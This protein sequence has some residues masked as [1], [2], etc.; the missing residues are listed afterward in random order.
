MKLPRF[1]LGLER[2]PVVA[3]RGKN[4]VWPI[5][6]RVVSQFRNP[7]DVGVGDTVYWLIGPERSE[8]YSRWHKKTFG[9]ECKCP[10]RRQKLNRRYPY[11][12][13]GRLVSGSPGTPP[14]PSGNP[15]EVNSSPGSQKPSNGPLEDGKPV[16]RELA[17]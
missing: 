14:G 9:R 17:N 12:P 7:E 3:K 8:A 13:P 10:Q 4:P 15:A 6:A 5:W 1:V 11:P 16:L 2:R